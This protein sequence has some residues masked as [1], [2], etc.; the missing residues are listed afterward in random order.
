M[1]KSFP[2]GRHIQLRRLDLRGAE[3]PG[4]NDLLLM[5]LRSIDRDRQRSDTCALFLRICE[6]NFVFASTGTAAE[7]TLL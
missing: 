1:Y 4:S 5:S 7:R 3:R 2:E 6:I